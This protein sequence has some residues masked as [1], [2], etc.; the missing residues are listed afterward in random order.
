MEKIS[1]SI[2]NE[3]EAKHWWFRVRRELLHAVFAKFLPSG[4]QRRILDI[5]CG[6]GLSSR[7][8]E[9]FGEVYSVDPSP[10]A[11]HF[12]RERGLKNVVEGFANKLP[13]PDNYFDVAIALDV[14]EHIEDA[15]ESVNEIRR[16]LKPQGIFV[17]Y[18]PAFMFLWG[19]NDVVRMHFRRYTKKTLL[20]LFSPEAWN[21]KKISYF[22]MFLL[23]V[24]WLGRKIRELVYK[25]P[26]DELEQVTWADPVLYWIFKSE[27][28]FLKRGN[29]PVGVSLLG[30]MEKK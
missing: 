27:L 30:V 28:W 22:N 12:C 21:I 11:L 19:Y 24:I 13:F 29:L 23:P 15:G 3:V 25:V 18:V 4:E 26:P 6:T 2:I 5:G 9:E 20:A 14:L 10:E 17:S 8:M 16:V 1:Y 7:L